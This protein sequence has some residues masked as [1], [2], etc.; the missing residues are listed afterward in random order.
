[1]P[2]H[3]ECSSS[4][5]VHYSRL[6]ASFGVDLSSPLVGIH[7]KLPAHTSITASSSNAAPFSRPSLLTFEQTE[8]H[9]PT[10]SDHAADRHMPAGY[11]GVR[12]SK[13]K[14]QLPDESIYGDVSKRLQLQP[15]PQP[16]QPQPPQ[17]QLSRPDARHLEIV[18]VTD[19][20]EDSDAAISDGAGFEYSNQE[21]L[22]Q[23]QQQRCDPSAA[24][25]SAAHA[26]NCP[27][28]L[29]RPP[30]IFKGVTAYINGYTGRCS[31]TDTPG[32]GTW[33]MSALHLQQVPPPPSC[34]PL[35]RCHNAP[36]A[37]AP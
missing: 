27:P 22:Q 30:Q 6:A 10:T 4:T 12:M 14:R 35:T 15:Q 37:R 2:V 21:H 16:P 7:K 13:L 24:P 34:T 20:S 31:S 29:D 8:Q 23:Q 1:M 9:G 33:N 28:S 26:E 36:R 19:D 5:Y 25:A 18:D 11:W 32:T 17:T 3:G